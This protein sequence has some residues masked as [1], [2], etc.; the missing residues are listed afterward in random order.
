L[1]NEELKRAVETI[2]LRVPLEEIVRERVPGLKKAGAL[3]VAC[4]PFHEERT[5]SFKVDPRRQSWNC[6]GACA[7]GGDVISF[8]QQMD[9]LEFMEVLEILAARTGV[10][11]P[12]R[13]R[14]PS[15]EGG[16]EVRLAL[17]RAEE[18]FQAA[19]VG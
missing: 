1:L 5:P 15:E 6:Y 17:A 9:R 4:C 10:E 3:W 8:L 7:T 2:K 19:L 13:G 14:G 12:R 11:L 16:D 18:S